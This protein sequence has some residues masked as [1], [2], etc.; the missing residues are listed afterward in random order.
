MSVP[1]PS[2]HPPRS[3]IDVANEIVAQIRK[4]E[5]MDAAID[6][7]A[8]GHENV[9]VRWLSR[10]RGYEVT[11]RLDAATLDGDPSRARAPT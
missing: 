5:R 2:G 8:P 4:D 3:I 6:A 7:Y 10:L 11:I 9:H 1:T